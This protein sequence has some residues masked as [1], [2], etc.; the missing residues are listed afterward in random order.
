VLPTPKKSRN[1]LLR[2]ILNSRPRII[3]NPFL[4][5]LQNLPDPLCRRLGSMAKAHCKTTTL[6]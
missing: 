1:N 2:T 3:L 6:P 4:A 5:V